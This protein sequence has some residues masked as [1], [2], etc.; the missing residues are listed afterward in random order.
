[1]DPLAYAAAVAAIGGAAGP[2]TTAAIEGARRVRAVIRNRTGRDVE[3]AGG[4][5]D[6]AA[7]QAAIG[8]LASF[9][10]GAMAE[11]PELRRLLRESLPER[12]ENTVYNT[13]TGEVHGVVAPGA[14]FGDL[15]FGSGR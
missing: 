13:T 5:A 9:L 2:V 11:D 3:D 10:E 15:H 12:Q 1:M 4:A 8:D 14:S 7:A 6:E